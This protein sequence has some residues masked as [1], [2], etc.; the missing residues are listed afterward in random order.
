VNILEQGETV[1]FFD[2]THPANLA[3]RMV[4]LFYDTSKRAR[5]SA[6]GIRLIREQYSIEKMAAVFEEAVAYALGTSHS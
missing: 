5:M 3:R 6:S 4:E 1:V 2:G